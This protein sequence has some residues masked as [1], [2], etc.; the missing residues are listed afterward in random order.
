MKTEIEITILVPVE[1]EYEAAN[2]GSFHEPAWP[3]SADWIDFD[4]DEVLK[5]IETELD[6]PDTSQTLK[7]IVAQELK[8]QAGEAAYERWLDRQI[9]DCINGRW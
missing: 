6:K 3:A 1:F 9:S 2:Q 4:H 5:R 7:D 8:E